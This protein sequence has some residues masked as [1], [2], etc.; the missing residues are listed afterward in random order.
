LPLLWAFRCLETALAVKLRVCYPSGNFAYSADRRIVDQLCRDGIAVP[1]FS[2][3]NH[4]RVL[5]CT[6]KSIDLGYS[7]CAANRTTRREIV[8][9]NSGQ[10][11]IVH[12]HRILTHGA[13]MRPPEQRLGWDL[14]PADVASFSKPELRR[15]EADRRRDH[16]PNEI[17]V[18]TYFLAFADG[19]F[20][21]LPKW[22]P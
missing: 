15:I 4:D 13:I 5:G 12:A 16:T 17:V 7:L 9:L 11:R 1:F 6:L 3:H 10:R 22:R 8:R 14:S 18:R 2:R 19:P 20:C 21:T